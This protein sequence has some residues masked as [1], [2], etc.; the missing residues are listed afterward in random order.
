VKTLNQGERQPMA[1]ADQVAVLYAATN[2]YVDRVN[3]NRVAEFHRELVERLHS[4]ASD[5]L[6]KIADGDWDDSTQKAL[7]E[8][9]EE[10]AGD[11]GYDLDEEGHPEDDGGDDDAKGSSKKDESDDNDEEESSKEPVGAGSRDD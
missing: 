11:F 6:E 1:V 3:V 5:T 4:S 10:F 8:A 7:D 9:I 2:G